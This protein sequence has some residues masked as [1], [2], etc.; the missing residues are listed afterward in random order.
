MGMRIGKLDLRRGERRRPGIGRAFAAALLAAAGAAGASGQAAPDAPTGAASRDAPFFSPAYARSSGSARGSV[1]GP[2]EEFKAALG[3]IEL[4]LAPRLPAGTRF[5]A[6]CEGLDS[7][8]LDLVLFKN[9]VIER[10]EADER[11]E[12]RLDAPLPDEALGS[13]NLR[14]TVTAGR[15]GEAFSPYLPFGAYEHDDFSLREPALELPDGRRIAPKSV[16]ALQGTGNLRIRRYVP[17]SVIEF[18]DGDVSGGAPEPSLPA[19]VSFEFSIPPEFMTDFELDLSPARAP[20]GEAAVVFRYAEGAP[21]SERPALVARLLVDAT[22]PELNLSGPAIGGTARG[23]LRLDAEARDGASGV[24]K[25]EA[26]LDGKTVALP[27]LAKAVGLSVGEHEFHVRARDFAGNESERA[28][29]FRTEDEAPMPPRV[30]PAAAGLVSAELV[31]PQGDSLRLELRRGWTL[32]AGDPSVRAFSG[33]YPLEPPAAPRGEDETPLEPALLAEADGRLAETRASSRFP[34]HRF[35]LELPEAPTDRVRVVWEGRTLPLRSLTAW[36]WDFEAEAWARKAAGPEGPLS[37]DLDAAREIRDGRANL[38]VLDPPAEARDE[39]PFTIAWISDPQY[40][41]AHYGAIYESMA[42]WLA[43]AYR[44]GEIAYLVDTGDVVDSAVDRGQWLVAD[45]AMGIIDE[46]GLPYGIAAGNHDV[47][48]EELIYDT[49]LYYFGDERAARRGYAV[50]GGSWRG[51]IHRYDLQSFGGRDFLFLYLGY[52]FESDPEAVE[53]ARSVLAAHPDRAAIVCLHSYLQAS[54]ATAGRAAP[55]F[56]NLVAPF[57]NVA[58]VLCGHIHGAAR[59]ERVLGLPGGGAR[60]VHELLADYQS[61]PMGGSGF[62]RLLRFDPGLGTLSVNTYSPWTG[63]T[64]FFSKEM[65][66][67]ELAVALP[68]AEKLVATDC[69]RVEVYGSELLGSLEGIRS[70]EIA[71]IAVPPGSEWYLAAEDTYGGRSASGVMRGD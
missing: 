23:D 25:V 35:E 48:Q 26:S 41:A 14:V 67:F 36:A 7:D 62:L 43:R 55:V 49:F 34:G 29:S 24:A 16:L 27:F 69:L 50:P 66:E 54:G 51:G 59:S 20:E 17:G 61:G 42:T 57:P 28:L 13:E 15:L 2:A 10:I 11:G 39:E 71:A 53:W 65:D 68:G 60:S 37:W 4:P 19:M 46:A 70:G 21:G 30:L 18:G 64:S 63:E 40:Y 12:A 52:G 9:G 47:Y 44:E 1:P 45:R 33:L 38:L 8:F 22:P 3:G 56:A 31:D 32:R 6:E 5:A 58:L